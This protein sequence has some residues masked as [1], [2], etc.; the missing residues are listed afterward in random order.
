MDGCWV[1]G[2]FFFLRKKGN[3][4]VFRGVLVIQTTHEQGSTV[5]NA[6]FATYHSSKYA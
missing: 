3:V 1:L 4:L 5:A 2:V 6:L